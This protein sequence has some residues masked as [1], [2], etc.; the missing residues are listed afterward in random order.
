MKNNY[1]KNRML[2]LMVLGIILFSGCRNGKVTITISPQTAIVDLG[3]TQQFQAT[4]TPSN[5]QVSWTVDE[6]D[7][8][9]TIVEDGL[10]IAQTCC[11]H[12]LLQQC[13]LVLSLI[14]P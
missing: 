4:V 11:H 7:A 6:G 13:E 12:L 5:A 14:R 1:Y 2:Y 8:W 3:Q 10:Y 9:G